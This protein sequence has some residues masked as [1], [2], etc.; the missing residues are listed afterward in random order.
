MV[1]ADV[2][3]VERQFGKIELHLNQTLLYVDQ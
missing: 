1:Y 3:A 2:L